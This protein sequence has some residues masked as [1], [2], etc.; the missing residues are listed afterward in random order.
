MI[1]I[2]TLELLMTLLSLEED[3]SLKWGLSAVCL[4]FISVLLDL[5]FLPSSYLSTRNKPS[6]PFRDTCF[7]TISLLMTVYLMFP[8]S[9]GE[10][11]PK[12]INGYVGSEGTADACI[13][14]S[15]V[16]HL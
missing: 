5:A 10:Q 12:A 15:V 2:I 11:P 8:I 9:Q 13:P 4:G 1:L 3:M 6:S 7:I 14:L 16:L